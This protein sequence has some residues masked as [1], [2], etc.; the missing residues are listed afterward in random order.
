MEPSAL[1][2]HAVVP[3]WVRPG[4]GYWE[5]PL[6]PGEVASG[7]AHAGVWAQAAALGTPVLILEDDVALQQGLCDLLHDLATVPQW[8]RVDLFYT[9]MHSVHDDFAH[10]Q[11]RRVTHNYGSSAYLVSPSFA[12]RLVD[13][14]LP[15]CAMAADEFLVFVGD[16]SY[17]RRGEFLAKCWPGRAGPPA[18]TWL[19][20]HRAGELA[21]ARPIPETAESDNEP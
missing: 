9:N 3:G 21:A 12:R 16:P 13:W 14:F 5:R 1:P 17:P 19:V 8:D 6:T 11:F 20:W 2:P 10:P 18:A 15:G 7:L 4:L